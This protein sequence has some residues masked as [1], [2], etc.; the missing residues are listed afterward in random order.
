LKNLARAIAFATT[1]TAS[2]LL[3][4]AL[5]DPVV[6]PA[7]IVADTTDNSQDVGQLI[8]PLMLLMIFVGMGY[9]H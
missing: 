9:G 2:P 7:V 6:E 5:S 3:A 1:F 8:I 4:G